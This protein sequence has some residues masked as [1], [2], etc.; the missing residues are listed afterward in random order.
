[1]AVI[2]AIGAGL[3][4]LGANALAIGALAGTAKTINDIKAGD[5]QRA[6]NKRL[7]AEQKARAS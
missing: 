2:S 7:V 5:E 3:G 1:M 6:E 4:W